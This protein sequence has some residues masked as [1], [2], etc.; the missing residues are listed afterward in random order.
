MVTVGG[1]AIYI[2]GR[3]NRDNYRREVLAISPDH[4]YTWTTVA[5]LQTGREKHCAVAVDQQE[6]LIIGKLYIHY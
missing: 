5:N 1:T 2:G 3:D 4:D 6:V